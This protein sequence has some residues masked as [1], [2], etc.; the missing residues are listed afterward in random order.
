MTKILHRRKWMLP[1]VVL[2]WASAMLAGCQ[3]HVSADGGQ[4]AITHDSDISSPKR[5]ELNMQWTGSEPPPIPA[6]ILHD[7]FAK[8]PK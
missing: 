5:R 1:A 3:A 8:G 2:A 4:N 6:N 7:F